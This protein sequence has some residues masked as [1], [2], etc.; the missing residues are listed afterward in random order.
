MIHL[1]VDKVNTGILELK[2]ITQEI[3]NE[4]FENGPSQKIAK[5]G[6]GWGEKVKA[7]YQHC[8][9]LQWQV[10]FHLQKRKNPD[11]SPYT[12]HHE[13]FAQY[14]QSANDEAERI[15]ET[16]KT[17]DHEKFNRLYVPESFPQRAAP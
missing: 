7:E 9:S 11:L 16:G 17:I 3:Q 12:K 1:L 5:A 14:L 8:A 6:K 15:I 2:D 4:H 10:R 13:D